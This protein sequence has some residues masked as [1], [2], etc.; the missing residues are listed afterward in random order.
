M[1]EIS[2]VVPV[3]NS[4]HYLVPCIE[5]IRRQTIRD[6][7]LIL[8]D[9]GSTDKSGKICDEYSARDN[10]IQVIHKKNEGVASARNTGIK[11]ASARFL[12]FVDSDDE[13]SFDNYLEDL[14]QYPDTDYIADGIRHRNIS[15]SSISERIAKLEPCRGYGMSSFPDAFFTNGFFHSC[16]GK[17]YSADL[18]HAHN[19]LFPRVRTSED[20]FFNL[21]YVKHIKD[22]K[23]LDKCGYC[24]IH[25]NTQE[26]ATARFELSDIDT[27][28]SLHDRML[29]LGIQKNVVKNTLYPQ[30]FACLRKCYKSNQDWSGKKAQMKTILSNKTVAKTLLFTKRN[31][32]EWLSGLVY[33]S[34]NYRLI[35]LWNRVTQ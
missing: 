21:E 8:V 18:I 32:G 7:E 22:W 33:C 16:C 3:Y 20:S 13:L 28:L 5:S 11:F 6:F 14:L 17:R 4:E 19:I 34:C 1:P 35:N 10:R 15:L 31:A 25:R 2:I 12:I 27:Y 9:D 26:N 23:M 30:Y 24:Y 29:E